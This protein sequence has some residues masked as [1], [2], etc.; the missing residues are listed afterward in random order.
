MLKLTFIQERKLLKRILG[1][2]KGTP[3]DLIY[4]ELK[5]TDIISRIKDLQYKFN[6]K[7]YTTSVE[8]AVVAH[9]YNMCKHLPL[10]KYYNHL[11]ADNQKAN[12]SNR[13]TN[14]DN[15]PLSMHLRYKAM[16]HLENRS[17]IIYDRNINE[18]H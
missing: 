10:F 17:N 7:I 11:C 14:V 5:R 13:K 9:A 3:N 18:V 16:F 6:Q 12:K 8:D 2:K 1:V 4:I 15:S